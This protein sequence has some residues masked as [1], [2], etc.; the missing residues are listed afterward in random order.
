[1]A[2]EPVRLASW[3]IQND[4][5]VTDLLNSDVTFVNQTLARHYGGQIR[6]TLQARG[7][8]LGRWFQKTR[9]ARADGIGRSLAQCGWNSR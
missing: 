8:A 1:M 6:P 7:L 5:P 3:L 2:E 4:R 9:L